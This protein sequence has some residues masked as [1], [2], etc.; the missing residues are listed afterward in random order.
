LELRSDD[1]AKVGRYKKIALD[2]KRV[3]DFFIAVF[4]QAHEESPKLIVIDLDSTDDPLHGKQE[5][6]FNE[7]N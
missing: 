3:D 6:R 5:G 2:E 1:P 7:R 4:T